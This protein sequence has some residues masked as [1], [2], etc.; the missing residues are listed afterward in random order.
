[1]RIS[2]KDKELELKKKKKEENWARSQRGEVLSPIFKQLLYVR[3]TA[4]LNTHM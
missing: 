4:M 1:M 2:E 3:C